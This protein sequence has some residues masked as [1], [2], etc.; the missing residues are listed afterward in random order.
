LPPFGER[1]EGIGHKTA[2]KSL[3]GGLF[4]RNFVPERRLIRRHVVA[5][6]GADPLV[7][8]VHA[9]A[10]DDRKQV[11][12]E[13]EVWSIA[14]LERAQHPREGLGNHIIDVGRGI[15]VLRGDLA[16]GTG[17]TFVEHTKGRRIA[18][19]YASD[20]LGIAGHLC[21]QRDHLVAHMPSSPPKHG[22]SSR[23][24]S[25]FVGAFHKGAHK[26]LM[27]HRPREV[28]KKS[29]KLLYPRHKPCADASHLA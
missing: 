2:L 23:Q 10:A 3:H 4:G 29:R 11:C 22:H 6:L 13:C 1:P 19:A 25:P 7:D 8:E 9:R 14:L 21:P 26:W 27:S 17:V 16:R 28:G 18:S 24:W 15:G 12:A 20:Q 5:R